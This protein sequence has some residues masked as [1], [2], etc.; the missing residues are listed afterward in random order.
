MGVNMMNL[1]SGLDTSLQRKVHNSD[2]GTLCV[3]LPQE[4]NVWEL[5]PFRGCVMRK[6]KKDA[7]LVCNPAC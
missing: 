4:S 6:T 3:P 2:S 5:Q 1:K 7:V